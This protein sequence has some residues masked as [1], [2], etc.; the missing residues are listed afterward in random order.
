MAVCG[1][2]IFIMFSTNSV[3]KIWSVIEPEYVIELFG[4]KHHQL[5]FQW[6][7]WNCFPTNASK[8]VIT[9][10]NCRIHHVQTKLNV[11]KIIHLLSKLVLMVGKEEILLIFK[12]KETIAATF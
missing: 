6:T 10:N 5:K 8:D 1:L 4:T 9:P 11:W 3:S 12:G 2:V 7:Y